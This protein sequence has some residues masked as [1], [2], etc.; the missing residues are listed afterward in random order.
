MEICIFCEGS[1]PYIS[2]GVSSWIDIL[3]NEMNDKK[4]KIVSIMPSR[5]ENLHYKYTIPSNVI[6]VKTIYLNDYID[7]NPNKKNKEPKLTKKEALEVKKFFRFCKDINWNLIGSIIH[8]KNKFGDCIEFLQSEFFWNM[9]LEIYKDKYSKEE[10]NRFFWTIRSMFVGFINIIQNNIPKADVYHSVSTG[11]AGFLGVLAKVKYNKPFVLTEHGIYAREREEEI[12]RAKWVSGIYK[13][14]WIEFFYFISIGAYKSADIVISLFDRNRKIQL[15]LGAIKEKSVVIPNGIDLSKFNIEHKKE[16]VFNI[17]SILR[18]VPIKDVKTLIRAFKLVKNKMFN[19]KLYLIGPHD[20]DRE[21]YKEC[22]KLV[23][24]LGLEY[25]VEFTGK[26]D[27]IKY[28]EKIDVLV[29]TS[30][31][32]GQPFVMLEGMAAKIPFVATDVGACREL[33]EGK[34]N[35]D[36]GVAGIITSP[37]SPN[38]TASAIIKLLNNEGLRKNMG[39]NGRERVEKYYTKESFIKNYNKI[40]ESLR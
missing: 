24:N 23:K 3:I 10:F 29:L 13:K 4:F 16:N 11:Y 22:L 9:I 14:I 26:V 27:I 39:E 30:I 2:G 19:V 18:I 15:E 31:S 20:E 33:L 17:G 34:E 7:L 6:E 37:V 25:D 40:Y 28:L 21:Y 32:E 8:N 38:D 35:D 12:I 5:E 1:Y 36:I